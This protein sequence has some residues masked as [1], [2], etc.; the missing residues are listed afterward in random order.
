MEEGQTEKK[1]WMEVGG[2]GE[3]SQSDG[4]SK[5]GKKGE[6]KSEAARDEGGRENV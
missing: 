6:E 2:G 1:R 5:G 3:K 4:R